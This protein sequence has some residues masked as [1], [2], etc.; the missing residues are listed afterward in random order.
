MAISG[1]GNSANVL[2]AVRLAGE[3]GATTIAFTGFQGGPLARMVDACITVPSDCMEQ[4][5]DV[6]LLLCHVIAIRL[7]TFPAQVDADS[8][9]LVA[10]R[11]AA[12]R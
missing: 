8:G 10:A 9:G 11:A 5:E 1:S 4:I 12:D 7:R 6:H 2:N 3:V